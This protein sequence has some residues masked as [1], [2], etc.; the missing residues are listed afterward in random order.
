MWRNWEK[1]K[2]FQIQLENQ[3]HLLDDE[4]RE[5]YTNMDD[6]NEQVVDA[7]HKTASNIA[8]KKKKTHSNK[9]SD[10]TRMLMEKRR[11]MKMDIKGIQNVEYTEACKTS[12][13]K[14]QETSIQ[15]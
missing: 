11:Q 14:T 10:R 3:F 7:I 6:W 9:I 4:H 15:R 8:G 2:K 5:I 12:Y 1:V 13:R